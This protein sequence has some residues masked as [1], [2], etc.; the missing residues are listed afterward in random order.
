MTEIEQK[1]AKQ[2]R[3]TK[4]LSRKYGSFSYDVNNNI[5]AIVGRNLKVEN[6]T[7]ESNGTPYFQAWVDGIQDDGSSHN[8][9]VKNAIK[10]TTT[11]TVE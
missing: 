5:V 11:V 9:A 10:K 3:S 6:L 4:N 1:A 7:K 8:E 2:M